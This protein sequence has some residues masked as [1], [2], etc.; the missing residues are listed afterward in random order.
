M[1]VQQFVS[2]WKE[3]ELSEIAVAQSHFIDVCS[4]I[5]HPAPTDADP[6]G[7]FFTFEITAEKPDGEPGRADAWYKGKFIWEYKRPGSDL[8][9]A[10]NQLL[11]Y[12]ES[13]G[14]PPLLITSDTHDII[15]HTNFTNTAKKIHIIDFERLLKGDG[16]NLLKNAFYEPDF[17]KP[18]ETQEHVTKATADTFISVANTL[19]QWLKANGESKQS[20]RLAHFIIRLLFSLFAEDMHLLPA[21]LFTQLV[22]QYRQ[23]TTA[24]LDDFIVSLRQLFS[25]MR[26]GGIFGFHRIHHFN[27]SLF[28]DDFVPDMPTDII[29]KLREACKQD[30]SNIDPSIFGTLFER[31]IDVSKRAQLGLHYTSRE[32]I[33]LIVEPVLMQPLRN[34]W[35]IT[36]QVVRELCNE[37]KSDEAH[38][39]LESFS[40][41]I[42]GIRVL[43]PACGSGNFLYVSLQRLLDLQKEV[44]AFAGQNNLPTIPLTVSPAQLYGIELNPYAHELA[45]ITV[46][47][48]YLQ[49]RFDNGFSEIQEPILR[50]LH[51]IERRDAIISTIN[52]N[53]TEPQWHEV[54]VIVGNPPFLGGGRRM[55]EELGDEYV[56]QLFELYR[57]R[58]SGGADLVCYWFEKARAMLASTKAK[59][60]GLLATQSIR[61][62]ANRQVLDRIKQTGDIFMAWSD[63]EWV[64]DGVMV[65]VSMVGFDS[66]EE[67]PKT[68]NGQPVSIINA[69]LTSSLDV[70]SAK[71]LKENQNICFKGIDKS[72]DF[73]LT[74]QQ[75]LAML[76]SNNATPVSNADVIKPYINALD[77][78]KHSRNM[79]IIDFTNMTLED[80]QKYEKPFEYVLEHVKP[81]RDTVRRQA[82]R[83]RW[84][85]FGE[86]RPGMC[87]S[88]ALL[89]RFVATPLTSKYRLYVWLSHPILSDQ[90]NFI[91]ARDDDYFFGVLHSSIHEIW[92]RRKGTQLREAESGSRYSPTETFETFPF[93][94]PLGKE[95]KE[96]KDKLCKA[97]A[98]QARKLDTFR[99]GWL[100]PPGI[101]VTFPE[102]IAKKRT[103]TS[104][105]NAL[106]QYRNNYKSRQH[107]VKQWE[108]D[109][110]YIITLDDIEELDYIHSELDHAV[111]DAYGWSYSLTEEQILEKLL[112]LNLEC[113]QGNN[114]AQ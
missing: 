109:V 93:P 27:G 33:S 98:E 73:E 64:Q 40:N 35:Q 2:K 58:L 16:F 32:D 7:E 83:E 12:R 91:F 4:L 53:V 107:D 77:I 51:N 87:K 112:E 30:W 95:P 89:S 17:F 76:K 41:E 26:D 34:K 67:T 72:G 104:L 36:K 80:A 1:N 69:D 37:N 105:Y 6:K 13:L 55:R 47:I 78:T 18:D 106:E 79:W 74:Q 39:I 108:K 29:H 62:G 60:V 96:N 14:N 15:I 102:S 9:K 71:Q 21:N 46:W 5:G 111:L 81:H 94:W 103:L 49:W 57:E 10:Y 97:I 84:W 85:Q 66:G 63:R 50:P 20:E 68:L 42:A 44:I 31:I 99:R 61:G 88:I 101:G 82:R 19:Q 24:H 45:Q 56:E 11:L 22:N 65:H 28:D 52:H 92:V 59:R 3:I 48:G 25:A 43:D 114:P 70:T 38:S 8:G 113:S 90:A 23:G 100:N 54:D 86:T 110:K 75:A